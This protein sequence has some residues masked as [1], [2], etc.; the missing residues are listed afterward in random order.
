MQVSGSGGVS[1][2]FSQTLCAHAGRT[3][4]LRHRPLDDRFGRP[5]R[6]GK[7][8]RTAADGFGARDGRA[9]GLDLGGDV[10]TGAQGESRKY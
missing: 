3:G 2:D 1:L 5:R 7:L 4:R 6:S 9:R 8:L 10:M